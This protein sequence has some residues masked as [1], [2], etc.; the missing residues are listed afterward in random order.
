[1]KLAA[2]VGHRA[3]GFTLVETLIVMVVL[4]IASVTIAQLTGN[5]FV[6]QTANR[7]IVVGTQLMQECAELLLSK[8]RD[9]FSDS[10]L[11]T[12]AAATACCSTYT[13]PGYSAP[14]I[15]LTAG[16]SGS[17]G[18]GACPYTTG[19]DCKLLSISQGGVKPVVLMLVLH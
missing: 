19:S 6:G 13:A 5:L 4:G 18:M 7:Q 10:C 1:M 17:A 12:S 16:N 11:A 3:R 2:V 15:T 8:S 14:A 9:N